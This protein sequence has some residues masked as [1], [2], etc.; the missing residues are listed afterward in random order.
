M[1]ASACRNI[2]DLCCLSSETVT[3]LSPALLN[4]AEQTELT[5]LWSVCRQVPEVTSQIF[6]V[7]SR[8]LVTIL[9]PALVNCGEFT[10]LPWPWSVCRHF[11]EA[12]FQIFAVLSYEAVII[13]SPALLNCAELTRLPWP[14]S[15]C[16]TWLKQHPKSLL[17]CPK[18]L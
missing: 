18:K 2:P 5:W 4:C 9:A 8:E 15:V 3:I 17:S 7:P 10:I 13:L 16:S 12:T 11:P 6:A 1:Q 14:W